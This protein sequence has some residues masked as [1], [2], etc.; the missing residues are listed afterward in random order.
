MSQGFGNRVTGVTQFIRR[1]AL[2][3]SL[4]ADSASDTLV[5]SHV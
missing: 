4:N 3:F 2:G 5:I 1:L